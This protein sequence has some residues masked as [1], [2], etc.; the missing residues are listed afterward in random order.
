MASFSA[1]GDAPPEPSG[2][3]PGAP[4]ISPTWTSSAK[5]VVGCSSRAGAA[6]VHARLRDRQRGLLSAGRYSADPR[7]RF[8]RRRPATGSGPRSSATRTTRCGRWRPACRQSRSST[9]TRAIRCGCASRRTRGATCWSSSATS[10]RPRV[11]MISGSM[12]SWRRISGRP[13]TTISRP[14]NAIAS[15]RV[16]MAEQGPFGLA[17]AAVD[18][19]QPDAFGAPAP[20]MSAQRRLAGFRDQRRDDLAIPDRRAG[21]CRAD[22][23]IAAAAS[24]RSA[25]AAAPNRPRH[26]PFRA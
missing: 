23:R 15:R 1:T 12:S 9:S 18:Q 24:W 6:M 5:D 4:G 17:L 22:G 2:H 21:Q 11:A 13:A 14:S 25:L 26:W 20:A 3:A 19:H 8:Y 7:S 16:L 10:T